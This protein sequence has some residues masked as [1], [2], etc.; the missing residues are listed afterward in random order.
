VARVAQG[1]HDKLEE[2]LERLARPTLKETLLDWD[3]AAA[4]RWLELGLLRR[5][6]PRRW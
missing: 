2:T 6:D 3:V 1:V 4:R 5:C